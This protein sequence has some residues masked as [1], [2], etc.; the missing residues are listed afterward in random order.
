MPIFEVVKFVPFGN[1]GARNPVDGTAGDQ[2]MRTQVSGGMRTLM[3]VY[4]PVVVGA[5]VVADTGPWPATA[6]ALVPV[7]GNLVHARICPTHA[8]GRCSLLVHAMRLVPGQLP[9]TYRTLKLRV[10]TFMIPE[11]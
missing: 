9:T 3:Q 4:C 6:A 5:V 7:D 11:S 10:V 8:L 1:G 2:S